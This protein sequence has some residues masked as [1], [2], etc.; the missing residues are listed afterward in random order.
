VG[1]LSEL[2]NPG[3][4]TMRKQPLYV[5]GREVSKPEEESQA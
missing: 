3:E 4:E 1:T 2:A 5:E